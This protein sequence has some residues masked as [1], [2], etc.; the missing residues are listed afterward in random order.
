MWNPKISKSRESNIQRERDLQLAKRVRSKDVV[1]VHFI[2][3]IYQLSYYWSNQKC[4][5]K[6]WRN[7]SHQ[8]PAKQQI[9]AHSV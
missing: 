1:G 8:P 5:L 3:E 7:T 2:A 9:C 4:V 6:I